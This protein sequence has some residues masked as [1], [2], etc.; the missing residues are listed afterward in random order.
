MRHTYT[1][2]EMRRAIDLADCTC[3]VC[4]RHHEVHPHEMIETTL[5]RP[6]LVEADALPLVLPLTRAGIIT[7][8]SCMDLAAVI[9]RLEPKTMGRYARQVDQPGLHYGHVVAREVAYVRFGL[10]DDRAVEWA[11]AVRELPDVVVRSGVVHPGLFGGAGRGIPVAQAEF[12]R[13]MAPR[14]V[15]LVGG[16][17]CV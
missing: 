13:G 12:P 3:T 4:I 8:A 14:L 7:V 2:D 11:K 15:E 1:A 17:L 10:V 9:R 16:A 6:A 5:G